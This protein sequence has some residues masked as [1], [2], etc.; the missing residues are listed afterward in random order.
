MSGFTESFNI[1]VSAAIL[2][3]YLTQKLREH[4]NIPWQ[5][6]ELEKDGIMLQWLRSTIKR[7]SLL[8]QHFLK[9]RETKKK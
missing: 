2:L 1:S 5:L 6:T 3:F 7:S 4:D 9:D 8:E